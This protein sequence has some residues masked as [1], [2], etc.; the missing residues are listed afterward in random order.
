MRAYFLDENKLYMGAKNKEI[1]V[2]K[3]GMRKYLYDANALE[4]NLNLN[5]LFFYPGDRQNANA[6][7]DALVWKVIFVT[8]LAQLWLVIGS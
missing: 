6:L 4:A 5:I 1:D 7:S 3:D 8:R 2:S